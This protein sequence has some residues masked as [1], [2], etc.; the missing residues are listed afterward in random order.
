LQNNAQI[1][2]ELISINQHKSGQLA[3]E[4]NLFKYVLVS[5]K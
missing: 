4:V 2:V 5:K 3:K 1:D